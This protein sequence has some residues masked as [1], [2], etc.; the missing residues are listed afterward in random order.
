MHS[1]IAQLEERL[2]TA[3][4]T[5]DVAGLDALIDDRLC[6]MGADGN[7]YGKA[8]DLALYRSGTQ[9][10][11]HIAIEDLLIEQHGSTAITVVLAD[12][13]GVLS[14]QP[15]EGRFRYMRTWVRG[16]LDW[17][18]VS[19]SVCSVGAPGL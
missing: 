3:M 13:A 17:K 18:I 6:F 16:E 1:D 15:F 8:D 5:S 2:R 11:T 7:L 12:L 4:S 14:G 10:I 9:R 19:G